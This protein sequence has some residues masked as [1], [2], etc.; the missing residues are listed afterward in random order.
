MY[1]YH[2]NCVGGN[3]AGLGILSHIC[4]TSVADGSI[5]GIMQMG[6]RNCGMVYNITFT[7]SG[8]S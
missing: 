5:E 2:C 4:N 6:I 8:Y 1:I 3:L 7:Y